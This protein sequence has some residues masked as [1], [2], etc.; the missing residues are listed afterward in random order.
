MYNDV[1]LNINSDGLILL[2]ENPGKVTFSGTS[3]AKITANNLVF[4]GFQYLNGSTREDV[5]KIS[6]NRNKISN[7]NIS[8]Y[9]SHYYFHITPTGRFNSVEYCN[10]ENKPPAPPQQE[11]TSIFQVAVDSIQP[12]YNTIRYCSFKNHTAP[13]N[14]GGDYGMEA[15][16]I[17]YSFQSKFVS[18]TIVEYCYFT[19]YNGDG[20]IISNKARENIFRYNIFDNNGE[21]HLTLRHGSDNAVYSNFFLNGAGIRIKEGQNQMVYNNYFNTGKFFSI[22]LENYK[23]DPLKNIIVTFNTFAGS[24]TIKLGGKGDFKPQDVL[25][26]NNLFAFSESETLS[27]ATGTEKFA[28]NLSDKTPGI[29]ISNGFS[30]VNELKLAKNRAGFYQL[31]ENSPA[32]GKAIPDFGKIL[33][34][35]DSND[36]PEISTDIMGNAR[37]ESGKQ[38]DV[39]CSE[40][41]GKK[42]LKL[43]ATIENTGLVYLQKTKDFPS[44]DKS[45]EKRTDSVV[46]DNEYVKVTH[47]ISSFTIAETTGYGTRIIVVLMNVKIKSSRGTINLKRGGVAA[48]SAKES[49]QAPTGEYFEVAFKTN[50]PPLKAPEQW[51]EPLKNKIVYE[52]KEIRIFEERLAPGDTRELHSHAQRVVVRLNHVPLTDPRFNPEVSPGGGIQVPN[53]ARFAEPMVHVV[54]N[55]SKDT[56]LFNIVIEY[57]IPHQ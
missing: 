2:A 46:V 9:R 33:D 25:F 47:N 27:D 26:S 14:S 29:A 32:I 10:F 4:S 3:I 1:I 17:G 23:V 56:P 21:S 24:G 30:V 40:F 43:Y 51:I 39:G 12:G 41:E 15:L 53:T 11:G 13:P 6:G 52:D 55:L 35:P 8:G 44:S 16:R 37:I 19:T 45:V 38:K 5:I 31:A 36:D 20:E 49:Y 28:G 50:H 57:K 22:R 54:K 48:F 7:I 18:H 42:K 34:I